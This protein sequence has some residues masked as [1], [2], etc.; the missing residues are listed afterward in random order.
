MCDCDALLLYAGDEDKEAKPRA[1]RAMSPESCIEAK[2][3]ICHFG[4]HLSRG[5]HLY[6]T[7]DYTRQEHLKPKLLYRKNKILYHFFLF[8]Y[9]SHFSRDGR[10]A[11]FLVEMGGKKG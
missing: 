9:E 3:A 1:R 10:K 4:K 11:P 7:G 8:L 5:K 6:C 2:I